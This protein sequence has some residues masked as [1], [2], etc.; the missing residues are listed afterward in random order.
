MKRGQRNPEEVWGYREK[1][2][3]EVA[4][5]GPW[6]EGCYRGRVLRER[7]SQETEKR[8]LQVTDKLRK[9]RNS[10]RRC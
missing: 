4:L 5:D 2:G 10:S 9:M 8:Y 7:F 1:S 6:R 3:K